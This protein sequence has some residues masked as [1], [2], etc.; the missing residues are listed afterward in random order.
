[1]L[2]ERRAA[3]LGLALGIN[4]LLLLALLG[5]GASRPDPTPMSEPTMVTFEPDTPEPPS[6]ASAPAKPPITPPVEPPPAATPP[7]IV[8]LP[9]VKKPALDLLVVSS[10]VLAASDIA[11]L[12]P[13]PQGAG[14]GAD[15]SE[16]AGRGPDGQLLYAAEWARRPT[17]AELNPYLPR[18]MPEEGWGLIACRTVAGR[19]VEDCVELES[20]PRTAYLARS[21]RNAAWQFRVRPPRKGGRE[22]VGEWVS[23]RIEYNRR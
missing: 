22:M 16:E 17:N 8:K 20:Y 21:V 18:N 10:E 3:G 23:I 19:R 14:S 5:L 6:P 2:P 12:P 13:A 4:L 15:D 1:M 11:N 7:P 9:P